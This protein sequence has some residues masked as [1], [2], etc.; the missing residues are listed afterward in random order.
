MDALAIESELQMA[1]ESEHWVVKTSAPSPFRHSNALR[2]RL[3]I[4]LRESIPAMPTLYYKYCDIS[5][6]LRE[7]LDHIVHFANHLLSLFVQTRCTRTFAPG[8]AILVTVGIWLRIPASKLDERAFNLDQGY[9]GMWR[10]CHGLPLDSEPS[11]EELD[12][13]SFQKCDINSLIIS[14]Y[15]LV[16]PCRAGACLV[17]ILGHQSREPRRTSGLTAV[18]LQQ[19][20]VIKATYQIIQK[21]R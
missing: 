15:N 3:K 16:F 21:P 10:R 11:I 5:R 7:S 6:L 14:I 4:Y 2:G 19:R 18:Q 8:H 9:I 12:I 13:R 17:P 1:W 20:P